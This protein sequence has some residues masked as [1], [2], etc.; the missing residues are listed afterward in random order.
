MW[1]LSAFSCSR[2]LREGIELTVTFSA[3]TA[4]T[5]GSGGTDVTT[6]AP[7]GGMGGMGGIGGMGGSELVGGGGAGGVESGAMMTSS[8]SAATTGSGGAA[9][10]LMETPVHGCLLKDTTDLTGGGLT[11]NVSYVPGTKAFSASVGGNIV[12]LPYPLCLKIK[13]NQKLVVTGS[14]AQGGPLLVSG[15]IDA[16]GVGTYD[17]KGPIQPNCFVAATSFDPNS[18]ACYNGG[19]W[20][21]GAP[22]ATAAGQCTLASQKPPFN[23]KTYPFYNNSLKEQQGALYVIP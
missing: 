20:P 19:T 3:V 10:V 15:F 2:P 13:F 14:N 8:S 9:P 1:T 7:M 11:V 6:S 12:Q 18:G 23:L 4:V 22:G 16:D 21:C 17:K 5:I